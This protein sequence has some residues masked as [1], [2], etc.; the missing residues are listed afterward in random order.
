MFRGQIE[1]TTR[2]CYKYLAKSLIRGTKVWKEKDK[3][4]FIDLGAITRLIT[5]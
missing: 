3:A 1:M 2:L 4:V 5:F